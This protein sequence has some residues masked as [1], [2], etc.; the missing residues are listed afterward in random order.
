MA[1]PLKILFVV[2]EAYPLVKTGG[3]GDVAGSLPPALRSLGVDARIMMPAYAEVLARIG[4]VRAQGS[5]GEI[6]PGSRAYLLTGELPGSDVPVLLVNSPDLFERRGSPYQQPEG[7]DWPDN[8]LRFGLLSRAAA[9][10]GTAGSL[11]GWQPDL[12]H[13]NDW[14]TGIVPLYVRM[15]PVPRPKTVFTIHNISYQGLFALP[16]AQSLGLADSAYT[17]NFEF[18]GK[19]SFLK[20]GLTLADC[21]ST[22]SPTYAREITMSGGGAG[23]EGV[24]ATRG[25]RIVGI[26]NGI[27]VTVWNPERDPFIAQPYSVAHLDLRAINTREL[28]REFGLPGDRPVAGVVSRL[29]EQ[30]GIDVLLSAI[31]GLLRA[32]IDLVVLGA[33][34]GPLERALM[35]A[36][37]TSPDRVGVRIGYDESLSHRIMA[38]SDL[39]LVPS[40][41]EPCGLTQLYAQHYGAMPV[42]HRVGGLADTVRDYIDGF[43]FDELSPHALTV[44]VERALRVYSDT[45]SWRH[46][47]IQA[48]TKEV[49]WNLCARHY[50]DLYRELASDGYA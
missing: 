33:G 31:P 17:A 32:G 47:Q 8:H 50:Y 49:G 12:V 11:A 39:L 5:F 6:L 27:D 4:S 45:L 29:V 23:L 16:L 9:L 1:Q 35:A 7:I 44:A 36:A 18:W 40:R 19:F 15:S 43:A 38:G 21:V 28:R 37:A 10:L 26:T 22:V 20:A 2:A 41:F 42:V 24:L 14:H 48:M 46:L 25:D 13:A 3:L 30:K 34:E